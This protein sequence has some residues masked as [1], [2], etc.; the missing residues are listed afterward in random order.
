MT[1]EEI[2]KLIERFEDEEDAISI[3]ESHSLL[4]GLIDREKRLK[5]AL[6]EAN[7]LLEHL[8]DQVTKL[9]KERDELNEKLKIATETLEYYSNPQNEVIYW[10]AQ[11]ALEKLKKELEA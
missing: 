3:S 6:N 1:N 10:I 11:E 4:C 8:R 9:K 5:I 7:D 2:N